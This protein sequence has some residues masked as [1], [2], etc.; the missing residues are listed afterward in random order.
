MVGVVCAR[1][2]GCLQQWEVFAGG[3]KTLLVWGGGPGDRGAW[4]TNAVLKRL[5]EVVRGDDLSSL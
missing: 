5:G 3:M 2:R 1:A 4:N